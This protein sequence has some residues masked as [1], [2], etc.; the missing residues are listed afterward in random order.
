MSQSWSSIPQLFYAQAE[1]WESRPL[2]YGKAFF[3]L[4]SIDLATSC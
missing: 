4:G 1:R 2:V 3:T